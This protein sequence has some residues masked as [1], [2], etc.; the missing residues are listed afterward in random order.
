MPMGPGTYGSK[1]GR[2][3]KKKPAAMKKKYKGLNPELIK[4]MA[5]LQSDSEK[6]YVFSAKKDSLEFGSILISKQFKNLIYLIGWSSEEGRKLN[7]NY[8]LLWEAITYF[9]TKECKVFDLGGLI[10]EGHP[11]DFFK[12]GMNG[13]YYENSGEYLVI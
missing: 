11:I 5:Q 1:K 10:G 3:M 9:K 7:V 8:L 12:L 4:K 6:L 2:P 13:D